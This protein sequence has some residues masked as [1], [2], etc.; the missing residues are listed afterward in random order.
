MGSH[1]RRAT[2]GR[3]GWPLGAMLVTSR[4]IWLARLFRQR[5]GHRKDCR[6]CRIW[7]RSTSRLDTYHEHP[8]QK[9]ANLRTRIAP[10]QPSGVAAVPCR[11]G[12]ATPWTGE[13]RMWSAAAVSSRIQQPPITARRTR[14]PQARIRRHRRPTAATPPGRGRT[15]APRPRRSVPPGT[16]LPTSPLPLT[17]PSAPHGRPR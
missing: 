17:R 1:V 12:Q 5:G 2:E 3:Q 8:S 13:Y 6:V 7:S 11:P 15:Y 16:P 14:S 9:P 4:S 10:V